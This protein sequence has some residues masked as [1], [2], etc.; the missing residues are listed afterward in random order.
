M[1]TSTATLS[2][3]ELSPTEKSAPTRRA[4][5][6]RTTPS[7]LKSVDNAKA[8]SA[9]LHPKEHGAY[10]ILG[11]PMVTALIMGGLNPIGMCIA[12]AAWA[13]FVAHEPLLV[14]WGHRG[15]RAQGNT[16][17][18]R[19]RLVI[20]LSVTLLAGSLAFVFGGPSLRWSIVAC[21]VLA[22][23]SFAVALA[24]LHRTLWGQLWGV[25]GLSLPCVP[26]LLTSG[27][28]TANATAVWGVW[29]VGFGATTLA[30]RSVIAAQ[31]RQS[32]W[33]H[34]SALAILSL[35]VTL[36]CIASQYWLLAS[37]PMLALSW[38][39]LWAPPPAKHLKR[40]GWTLVAGTALSATLIVGIF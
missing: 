12:I 25:A 14:V 38:Y 1:N 5:M 34:T 15:L 30:V 6:E 35:L 32:R 17:A 4:E 31:K 27:L 19:S 26:I 28:S 13:G 3:T 16:P 21:V 22:S 10:A 33:L 37:L 39:L 7:P 8:Q 23:T 2:S 24:G 40:V 18:A 11:I 20:L 36:G 29:L 9:K